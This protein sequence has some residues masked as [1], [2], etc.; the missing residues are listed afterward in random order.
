MVISTSDLLGFLV[1]SSYLTKLEKMCILLCLVH[2]QPTGLAPLLRRSDEGILKQKEVKRVLA[3][4]RRAV[5]RRDDKAHHRACG[6]YHDMCSKHLLASAHQ[7][8]AILYKRL[9]E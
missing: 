9:P 6:E 7:D 1:R 8:M 4:I 5:S 2:F 3:R